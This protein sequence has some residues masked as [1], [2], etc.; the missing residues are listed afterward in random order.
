MTYLLVGAPVEK[1]KM[2]K[3]VFIAFALLSV[4]ALKIPSSFA[5]CDARTGNATFRGAINHLASVC[6]PRT[7]TLGD[8][9]DPRGGGY[10]T[11]LLVSL[12]NSGCGSDLTR[13]V[14]GCMENLG[15]TASNSF[16]SSL[17]VTPPETQ[18]ETQPSQCGDGIVQPELGEQCERPSVGNCNAVCRW[19]ESKCGD[20]RVDFGTGEE[21]EP[22]A[23]RHDGWECNEHCKVKKTPP[24]PRCGDGAVNQVSEECDEPAGT[25]TCTADCKTI[26][27]CGDGIVQ[28]ELGE[29]CERPNV[30][31]CDSH[32]KKI[33]N[34][35]PPNEAAPF[36][37]DGI[38]QTDRGEQCETAG[39]G[40]CSDTCKIV[41]S[42]DTALVQET[43]ELLLEGSGMKCSMAI[44][45]FRMNPWQA[46][47]IFILSFASISG[48]WMLRR[49]KKYSISTFN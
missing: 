1:P 4:L 22:P 3:Y 15:C 47:S 38:L 43:L 32:C 35:P 13:T 5:D 39:V 40:N 19:I 20:G 11:A 9:R 8:C 6:G 45:S 49:K 42:G 24:A 18:P 16:Y 12:S 36:C 27:F 33:V 30:G 14:C 17:C 2:K 10:E 28:A 48:F 25:S 31:I 44:Q 34:P 37:G 21:C 23:T 29:E 7:T 26:K 46:A 41:P